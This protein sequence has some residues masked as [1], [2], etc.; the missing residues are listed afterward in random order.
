MKKTYFFPDRATG[1]SNIFIFNWKF[2]DS[3]TNELLVSIYERT[4]TSIVS[5]NKKY[6][7]FRYG[8]DGKYFET[9]TAAAEE[10]MLYMTSLGYERLPDHLKVIK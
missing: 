8:I 3:I 4:Q 6:Y 9:F 10:A 2:I 7:L 5:Q 1:W